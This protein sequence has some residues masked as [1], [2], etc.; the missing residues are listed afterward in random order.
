MSVQTILALSSL[1]RRLDGLMIRS[2]AAAAP[3]I[4]MINSW[5]ITVREQMRT[6]YDYPENV[7]SDIKFNIA[8]IEK[9]KNGETFRIK[10][11]D[12]K[13]K[14]I[15]DGKWDDFS[16]KIF[17][18][19]VE[20]RETQHSSGPIFETTEDYVMVYIR[21]LNNEN[22]TFEVSWNRSYSG[23]TR[24]GVDVPECSAVHEYHR[25]KLTGT[26]V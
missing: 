19:H 3:E 23:K 1:D 14:L 11:T 15:H 5:R 4:E 18:V 10:V 6:S 12:Q 24:G 21:S 2:A 7:S 9:Y 26:N 25:E 16:M 17:T 20:V 13:G 22:A 8:I